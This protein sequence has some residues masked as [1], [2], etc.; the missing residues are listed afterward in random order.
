MGS[1]RKERIRTSRRDTNRPPCSPLRRRKPSPRDGVRS[2][3]G[4]LSDH[5]PP[6]CTVCGRARH[7]VATDTNTRLADIHLRARVV[8]VASCPIRCENIRAARRGI[9][10]SRPMARIECHAGHDAAGARSVATRIVDGAQVVIVTGAARELWDGTAP[11]G[12]AVAH[13]DRTVI[14]PRAGHSL[15]S[16]EENPHLGRVVGRR[17][18]VGSSVPIEVAERD[19]NLIAR[20]VDRRTIRLSKIAVPRSE[21]NAHG[22]DVRVPNDEVELAV[23]VNIR[24]HHGAGSPEDPQG[25]RRLKTTVPVAPEDRDVR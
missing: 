19:L 8:V 12:R 15:R 25:V 22:V 9:A 16:V 7:G 24:S 11:T 20:Q 6:S 5:I 1:G 18:D 4:R 21:E 10:R 17:D 23:E 3:I 13:I 14:A 2:R